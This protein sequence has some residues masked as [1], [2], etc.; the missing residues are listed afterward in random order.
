MIGVRARAERNAGRAALLVWVLV[1]EASP[2]VHTPESA[3]ASADLLVA[4]ATSPNAAPLDACS[5]FGLVGSATS[6]APAQTPPYE[7]FDASP[8][9]AWWPFTRPRRPPLYESN[10]H[11]VTPH[12]AVARVIVPEG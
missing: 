5:Y 6:R 12:A 8:R 10:P 7:K 11:S 9:T 3:C 4:E 2:L 1:C